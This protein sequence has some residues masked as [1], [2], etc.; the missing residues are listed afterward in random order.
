[1]KFRIFNKET[2]QYEYV[3][4]NA[5]EVSLLDM[6]GNFESPNVEGALREL[7]NKAKNNADIDE[8]KIDVATNKQLMSN[9]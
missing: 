8:L 2:N 5:S 3:T 7:A 9:K 4:Q 6:E 1:M